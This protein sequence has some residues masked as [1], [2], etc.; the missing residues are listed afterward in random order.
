MNQKKLEEIENKEYEICKGVTVKFKEL[1][2]DEA[3]AV[4]KLIPE[5]KTNSLMMSFDAFDTRKLLGLILERIDGEEIQVG[6]IKA[7]V[8]GEII[9]DFLLLRLVTNH[10]SMLDFSESMEKLKS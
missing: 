4:D 1:D 9:K 7:K 2:L 5:L 3:E 6:K 8:A 10:L